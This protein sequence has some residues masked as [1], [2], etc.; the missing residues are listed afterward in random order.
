VWWGDVKQRG[1]FGGPALDGRI[2]LRWIFRKCDGGVWTGSGWLRIGT[3]DTCECGDEPSSSIKCWEFLD[4]LKI[5]YL[6]MK[7]TAA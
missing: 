1:H 4:K 7:V 6:L 3:G 5:S 2:I